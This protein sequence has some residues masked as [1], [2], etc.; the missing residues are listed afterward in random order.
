MLRAC[1]RELEVVLQRGARQLCFEA[2]P[3]GVQSRAGLGL[4]KRSASCPGA[5]CRSPRYAAAVRGSSKPWLRDLRWSA[6]CTLRLRAVVLRGTSSIPGPGAPNRPGP[7]VRAAQHRSRRSGH[8]PR[9]GRSSSS[10]WCFLYRRSNPDGPR[11]AL[12]GRS[13]R[14][15]GTVSPADHGLQSPTRTSGAACRPRLR[16]L[17]LPSKGP[18]QEPDWALAVSQSPLAPAGVQLSVA[19]SGWDAPSRFHR[20]SAAPRG[21]AASAR[22]PAPRVTAGRGDS[23]GG[24]NRPVAAHPG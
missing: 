5:S 3:L 15:M 24:A 4:K 19:H 11:T 12:G 13:R 21:P 16:S 17:G 6:E 10:P 9:A 23:R 1:R 22:G 2:L 7:W 14:P 8:S 18:A 20:R